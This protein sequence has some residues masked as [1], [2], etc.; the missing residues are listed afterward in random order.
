MEGLECYEPKDNLSGDDIKCKGG[1]DHRQVPTDDYD[2]IID[3]TQTQGQLAAQ[4]VSD[5]LPLDNVLDLANHEPQVDAILPGDDI[6]CHYVEV[7]EGSDNSDVV[8]NRG[9]SEVSDPSDV[10]D[11]FKIEN[12]PE[13]VPPFWYDNSAYRCLRIGKGLMADLIND[14]IVALIRAFHMEN[15]V[16]YVNS[17]LFTNSQKFSYK[18]ILRDAVHA[19]ALLFPVMLIGV[20]ISN[21]YVLAAV[22]FKFREITVIDSLPGSDNVEVFQAVMYFLAATYISQGL[23]LPK[24]WRCILERTSQ[25][26]PDGSS[27]G[28]YVIYHA[29]CLLRK[30]PLSRY[31]DYIPSGRRWVLDCLRRIDMPVKVPRKRPQKRIVPRDA[32]KFRSLL[33]GLEMPV[34]NPEKACGV[35]NII[36]SIREN[37]SNACEFECCEIEQS[38]KVCT[39]VYCR[40]KLHEA[41]V[42]PCFR[43]STELFLCQDCSAIAT[44]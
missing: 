4:Q 10:L 31:A 8:S 5:T 24:T 34:I 13:S 12:A 27:C 32:E 20:H 30:R 44:V 15:T 21:H 33:A 38:E 18:R 7:M 39:C 35:H 17:Y 36:L 16:L 29:H 19:E 6:N 40:A 11:A 25:I 22:N 23:K 9:F 1:T 14:M 26:Q 37:D 2:M 41:H 28:V 43:A 42:D 3:C